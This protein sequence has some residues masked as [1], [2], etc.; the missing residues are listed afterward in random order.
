ML[1]RTAAVAALCVSVAWLSGCMTVASP[2]IGTIIAD[3]AWDGEATAVGAKEGKACAKSIFGFVAQGDASIKAA[4]AAG[5][6]KNI[7]R[8]D[9]HTKNILGFGD[10]CTVVGGN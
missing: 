2:A 10:Y 4:A 9:H 7:T 1:K 8:V 3:V 6:I 5:G